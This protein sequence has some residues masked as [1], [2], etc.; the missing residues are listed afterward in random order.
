[1]WAPSA[2]PSSPA[3]R[4]VV[5]LD[6]RVVIGQKEEALHARRLAGDDGGADGAHI[7]A[8]VRRA[9]GGDAGENAV[10]HG[11]HEKKAEIGVLEAAWS[12]TRAWRSPRRDCAACAGRLTPGMA[13]RR[14]L[15]YAHR[16]SLPNA[17]VAPRL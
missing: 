8:Q 2:P 17:P 13:V 5:A 16:L 12:A 10:A 7:V 15:R 3:R 6:Q 14:R 11:V 4:R 9:A 1:M